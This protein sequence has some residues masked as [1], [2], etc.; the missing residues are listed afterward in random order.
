M[1]QK[2]RTRKFRVPDI[3]RRDLPQ[4][5]RQDEHA[6]DCAYAGDD[7]EHPMMSAIFHAAGPDVCRERLET[8]RNIDIASTILD[9]LNVRPSDTVQG[10]AIR[11]CSG[12]EQARD[13]SILQ[14]NRR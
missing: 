12:R 2:P 5:Q 8:V 11:L 6:H 10:R 13:D 9:L 1:P 4:S 7:P 3:T 14:T